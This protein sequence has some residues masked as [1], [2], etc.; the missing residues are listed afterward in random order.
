MADGQVVFEIKG[1]PSNV[2]QTVKQVTNNIQQESKKWD[3]AADKATGDIEKSF[4]NMAGSIVGTLAAAG[5]GSI[6][7]RPRLSV[8]MGTR[9]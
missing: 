3:Q 8:R 1:D 9:V 2:N 7:I 6:L 5:I 4:S